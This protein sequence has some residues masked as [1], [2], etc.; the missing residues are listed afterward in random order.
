[1]TDYP[2]TNEKMLLCNNILSQH[3]GSTIIVAKFA[4]YLFCLNESQHSPPSV[5]YMGPVAFQIWI[6]LNKDIGKEMTQE[7]IYI[8]KSNQTFSLKY[9]FKKLMQKY[10]S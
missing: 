5:Y 7:S 8:V 6:H 1:M 2:K 10:N 4:L 9:Y 3:N